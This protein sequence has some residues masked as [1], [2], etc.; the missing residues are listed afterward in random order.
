MKALIAV[1]FLGLAIN[2]SAAVNLSARD[3]R[4]ACEE[5]ADDI[6]DR[7]TGIESFTTKACLEGSFDTD[8]DSVTGDLI[9]QYHLSSVP[10]LEE[11]EQWIACELKKDHQG[12]ELSWCSIEG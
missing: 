10:E 12:L 2:A 11:T 5:M 6:R 3:Q 4:L 8:I 9:I 7:Y 1:L